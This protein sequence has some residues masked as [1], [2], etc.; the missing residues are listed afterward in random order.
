LFALRPGRTHFALD[1]DV[2]RHNVTGALDAFTDGG[3]TPDRRGRGECRTSLNN[4]SPGIYGDASA[5]RPIAMPRY[6]R[7]WRLRL[8]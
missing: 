5:V 2:D 7:F 8:R 3:R 4:V 1:V 6:V